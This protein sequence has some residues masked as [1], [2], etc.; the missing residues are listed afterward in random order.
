MYDVASALPYR[1]ASLHKL[2]LAMKYGGDYTLR[3]RTSSMWGVVAGEFG[4][5]EDEVRQRA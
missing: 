3:E 5:P 1:K 4:L 2:R